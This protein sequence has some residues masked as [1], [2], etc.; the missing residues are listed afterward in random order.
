MKFL[1]N[2]FIIILITSCN[3]SKKVENT[4]VIDKILPS[5]F[6]NGDRI[7]LKI[8]TIKSDSILV[9]TDTGGGF[10]AIYPNAIEKLT[11]EE[12]VTR[13]EDEM[14]FIYAEDIILSNDYHPYIG[15]M[16]ETE[17]PYFAA[18]SKEFMAKHS[19]P[20]NEEGFFGQYF[21]MKEIWTFD[22]L[23]QKV[24]LHKESPIKS[25]NA[26]VLEIG[27]KKDEKGKTLYGHSSFE[28]VVNGEKIPMLFDTGATFSLSEAAQNKFKNKKRIGGSFIAKSVFERWKAAHPDWEIIEGADIIKEGGEE[29]TFDMIQVP[30]VK[31]GTYE[32]GPVWFSMRPDEA[33]SKG[34]IRSMDKVVKGA[35]GGSAL[36]YLIVTIDYKNELLEFKK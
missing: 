8:P 35:L 19:F 13:P 21:F 28:I 31:L 24:I 2:L 4:G 16:S 30:V 26:N 9:Y 29:Y 12:K 25:I 15:K 5:V 11:L 10:T 7:Y 1:A 18:P 22:Y 3:T 20:Q 14:A 36:K 34:M 6:D 23:T 32:V 17:K 33:W 27:F